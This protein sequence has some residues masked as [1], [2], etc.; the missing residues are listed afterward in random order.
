MSNPVSAMERLNHGFGKILRGISSPSVAS[1][2]LVI[3]GNAHLELKDRHNL[4]GTCVTEKGSRV[5]LSIVFSKPEDIDEGLVEIPDID[6]LSHRLEG[7]ISWWH[8]WCDKGQFG[9][10]YAS[11]NQTVRHGAQGSYKCAQPGP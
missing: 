5:Y 4:V 6:E 3:S 11:P 10:R 9:G 8:V 2:G 1:H 7:T